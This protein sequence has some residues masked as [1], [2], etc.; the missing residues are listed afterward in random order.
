MARGG[1]VADAKEIVHEE[2]LCLKY[3][4]NVMRWRGG[5]RTS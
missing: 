3:L 1:E 4:Q 2:N 5:D